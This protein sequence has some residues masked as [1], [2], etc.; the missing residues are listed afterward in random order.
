MAE[1]RIAD[2][3]EIYDEFDENEAEHRL[4]LSQW[5]AFCQVNVRYITTFLTG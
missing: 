4:Y 3:E 5:C 1:N 2:F